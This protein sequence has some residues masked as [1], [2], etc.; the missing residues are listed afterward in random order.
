MGLE[1]EP[2]A[3]IPDLW[4][5]AC[6]LGWLGMLIPAEYGGSG[7]TALEGAVVYEELGRAIALNAP[8]VGMAST[9]SGRGYWLVGGDGGIFKC[10]LHRGDSAQHAL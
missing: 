7:M 6:G 10:S 8:I 5:K 2:S 3:L 1:N 9:P 4:K